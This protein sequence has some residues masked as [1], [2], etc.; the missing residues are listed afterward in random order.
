VT[1]VL[2]LDSG[3]L[4]ACVDPRHGGEIISLI[5]RESGRDLLAHPPFSPEPSTGCELDFESWVRG[6]RGGWQFIGPNVGAACTVSGD[7]HGF[8]GCASVDTWSVER[9]SPAE[10]VLSWTGHGLA[11][12]RRLAID[13]RSMKVEVEARAA[14]QGAPFL[15]AEHIAFGAAVLDPEVTLGLP[16]A[17]TY[18]WGT[19]DGPTSPPAEAP[20]WPH[21][22]LL[23]GTVERVDRFP[24]DHVGGRLLT[25]ADIA[26][27]RATLHNSA[28]GIHL[29][30]GWEGSVLKHMWLWREERTV[31]GPWRGTSSMLVLEPASIPNDGGLATAIDQG[32]A[33]QLAPG[34][35]TMYR[36]SLSVLSDKAPVRQG[37]SQKHATRP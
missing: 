27:G 24:H 15:F 1:G 29:E 25:V 4:L 16:A 20:N 21:A 22:L 35:S 10:A 19:P 5:D 8:H 31:G 17:K 23:D 30:L 37:G 6:Y 28:R 14:H 18:Q 2:V 13:G 34:E 32:Q 33:G 9:S 7:A 12:R 26:D 11:I 3:A 36:M